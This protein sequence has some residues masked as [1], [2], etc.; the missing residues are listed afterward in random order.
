MPTECRPICF[1]SCTKPHQD[2]TPSDKTPPFIVSY[3]T[4]P[5]HIVYKILVNGIMLYKLL[6]IGIMLNIIFVIMMNM[7]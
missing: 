2:K 7:I 3:M 1:E 4:E 5:H 6:V